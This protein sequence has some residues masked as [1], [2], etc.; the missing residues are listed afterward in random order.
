MKKHF[1]LAKNAPK[2]TVLKATREAREKKILRPI[3]LPYQPP[4]SSTFLSEQTSH[5]QPASGTFSLTTN[6]RQ[7][8]ATTQT[9]GLLV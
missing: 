5:Q 9:N 8:S 4:V 7:S 3:R 1:V 6:Q 2:K